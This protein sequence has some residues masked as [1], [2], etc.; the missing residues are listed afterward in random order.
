MSSCR[1]GRGA[2]G[3]SEEIGFEDE[4]KK[5]QRPPR[6][7]PCCAHREALT[8]SIAVDVAAARTIMSLNHILKLDDTRDFYE[9]VE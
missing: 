6:C 1:E 9:Y 5:V 7:A 4:R 3:H 8:H 2:A